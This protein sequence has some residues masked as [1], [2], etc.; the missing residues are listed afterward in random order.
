MQ[1]YNKLIGFTKWKMYRLTGKSQDYLDVL[2]SAYLRNEDIHKAITNECFLLLKEKWIRNQH[3]YG[4]NPPEQKQ[5]RKCKETLCISEFRIFKE[6]KFDVKRVRF[7]CKKCETKYQRKYIYRQRERMKEFVDN[8]DQ[9]ILKKI[10][11]T[12]NTKS[13]RKIYYICKKLGSAK[14]TP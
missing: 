12:Y 3:R 8:L 14:P 6:L 5:C 10:Q 13:F 9:G 2:H 11:E 7:I 1:D 4:F